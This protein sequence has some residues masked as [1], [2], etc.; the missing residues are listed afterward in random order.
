MI[1]TALPLM[2]AGLLQAQDAVPPPPSPSA[3]GTAQVAAPIEVMPTPATDAAGSLDNGPLD[4]GSKTQSRWFVRLGVLGALYE[5]HATIATNGRVL[6]GATARVTDNV[7]LMFDIGY[8]LSDRFAVM[9]MAG[10]PP[11]PAV[12]GE[13]SVS[14]FGTLGSVLY[15]PVF[16]TG[17]YRLPEWRGFRPYVGAGV[18]RAII[19]RNHD[20]AVTG[21]KVHDNWGP[22]LQAVVERRL[23][24]GPDLF[25]DY[26][27]LWL[28]VNA[29]GQ[30][31]NAPVRA[32][33]TLDPNVISVGVKFHF[34]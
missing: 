16:L 2:F 10:V 27:R 15:G 34:R 6:P 7:T 12:I 4:S 28:Y 1:Q 9:L 14:S 22:A 11:R 23:K 30:L 33:V 32:R 29:Q 18:A 8:D 20:G 25:V 31:A 13:G 24:N 19:L 5:S 21:L 17:V 26:K 3:T